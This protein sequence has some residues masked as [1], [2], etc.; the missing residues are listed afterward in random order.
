VLFKDAFPIFVVFSSFASFNVSAFP[1]NEQDGAFRRARVL[2]TTPATWVSP[3]ETAVNTAVP[4]RVPSIH[5]S[6]EGVIENIIDIEKRI[7]KTLEA[8]QVL[9]CAD[10]VT[11]I[12][13]WDG[14][15][16]P[17]NPMNFSRSRKWTITMVT[18]F[19]TLTVSFAS[20]VFSTAKTVTAKEFGASLEVMILGVSLYVLGFA[21][22]ELQQVRIQS[23]SDHKPGLGVL[24]AKFTAELAPS[25]LVS[26]YSPFPKYQLPLHR[27]LRQ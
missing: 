22:G 25:L 17:Q 10:P 26:P 27:I 4:S 2:Q 14:P 24:S 5:T 18:A 12:V 13:G 8:V 19:I 16:D 3:S 21:Y 15:D 9:A 6:D 20:S 7:S 11:H 23:M 1:M